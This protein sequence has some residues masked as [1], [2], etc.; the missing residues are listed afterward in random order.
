MM[1]KNFNLPSGTIAS[2]ISKPEEEQEACPVCGED[3]IP[4][5]EDRCPACGY[6]F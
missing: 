6:E 4:T 5:D 1:T 2:D 3:V